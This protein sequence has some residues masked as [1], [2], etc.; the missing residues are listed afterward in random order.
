MANVTIKQEHGF[1]AIDK[2]NMISVPRD[3]KKLDHPITITGAIIYDTVDTSTG[4][5]KPIGAVKTTDGDIYGFTSA[6]LIECTDM[7]I[8]VFA[9]GATEITLKPI[10]SQSKSDR[11]FYQFKVIEVK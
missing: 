6:T 5:V 7:I 10:S 8:D 4:E 1:N 11:T 3:I 9:D 2:L